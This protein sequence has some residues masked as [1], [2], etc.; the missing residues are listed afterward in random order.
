MIEAERILAQKLFGVLEQFKNPKKFPKSGTAKMLQEKDAKFFQ[1]RAKEE[2][3]ELIDEEHRHSDDFK[4]DFLLE[5]SQF[6]YWLSLAAIVDGKSFAEAEKDFEKDL[7]K[8]EK[9]CEENK[10]SLAEIFQK[11]LDE[12][13]EKGYC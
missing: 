3:G 9:L 13:R 6:F 2:W 5:S 7:E 11:D 4:Q 1:S 10:I 8:L 12:C